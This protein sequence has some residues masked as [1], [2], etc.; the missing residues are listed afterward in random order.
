M[1]KLDVTVIIINY[2]TPQ[3]TIE[4]VQSVL[5]YTSG[6]SYEIIVIDNASSD[7]S[8]SEIKAA[9]TDEIIFIENKVNVGFGKANNQGIEIAKGEFVFLLNSD[10]FLTSNGLLEFVNFMRMPGNEKVAFCGAALFTGREDTI[11]SYGN[12]PTLL[13]AF[14]SIGFY[15]LYKN[16]YVENISAGVTNRSQEIRQVDYI[17]G[18]DIFIRKSCLDAHGAFDRDFFLY[19]EETELAFR[20]HQKGYVAYM[21]PDVRIIHLGNGSQQTRK[22]FNYVN[23]GHYCKG[24]DLYFKKCHGIVYSY[25]VR[26]C[27]AVTE[28]NLSVT[29]KRN[30][31]L[32][33]KLKAILFPV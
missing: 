29:G 25:L 24:R 16:Y 22:R 21:L 13:E 10:A 23:F 26:L 30:G 27:Y 17:N 14:S 15:L 18:A 4:S 2:N 12:F 6:I 9:Y 31:N 32:L 19:F 1:H 33:R 8:V 7:T 3:L 28:I 20:M 11:V 5:T